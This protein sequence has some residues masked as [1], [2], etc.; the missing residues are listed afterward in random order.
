MKRVGATALAVLMVLSVGTVSGCKGRKRGKNR[1]TS[2]AGAPATTGPGRNTASPSRSAAQAAGKG[3][4]ELLAQVTSA[5]KMQWRLDDGATQAT[6][7][8]QRKPGSRSC[9]FVVSGT[10]AFPPAMMAV[11]LYR[12][13]PDVD[14][15]EKVRDRAAKQA[16]NCAE[17]VSGPAGAS[18]SVQCLKKQGGTMFEVRTT[19]SGTNGYVLALVSVQPPS[20]ASSTLQTRARE[21][22]HSAAGIGFEAI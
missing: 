22:S 16:D 6:P 9:Q 21:V 7:E 8:S 3:C 2:H 4:G 1:S 12:P 5:T 11:H 14:T 18:L 19:Y 17:K 10:S 15:P 20:A 13:S